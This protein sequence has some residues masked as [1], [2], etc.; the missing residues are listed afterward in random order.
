VTFSWKRGFKH[1]LIPV[2]LVIVAAVVLSTTRHIADPEKFGEGVGRFA[3]VCLGL[4]LGISALI[5]KGKHGAAWALGL[6]LA[7]LIV[8]GTIYL[9][10]AE[11]APRA[12]VV[13]DHSP[14]VEDGLRL[15]H[16]SL[17]FSIRRPPA[18]FKLSPQVAAS[19]GTMDPD[20]VTYAYAED[21]PTSVLAV[22]V[23]YGMTGDDLGDAVKGIKA[24]LSKGGPVRWIRDDL[25][26]TEAHIHGVVSGAHV[27]VAAYQLP[28]AV[29]T[30]MTVALEADTL[31]DVLA[32]F[33]R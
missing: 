11:R 5:Q 6:S 23:M 27:Q 13:V 31:A 26:K 33:Q 12:H 9:V 29:V 16:P 20:V 4:G 28:T 18:S 2:A 25:G 14:L 3:A 30:V 19:M 10:V 7:G 17:G 8:G 21:P 24:G 32:S 1:A 22:S 15:R